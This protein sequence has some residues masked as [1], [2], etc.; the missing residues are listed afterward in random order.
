MIVL[1]CLKAAD[2]VV[3]DIEGLRIRQPNVVVWSEGE[4]YYLAIRDGRLIPTPPE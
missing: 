3:A 2:Q 1:N 4:A